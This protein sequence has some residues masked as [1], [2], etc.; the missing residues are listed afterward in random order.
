MSE[1]QKRVSPVAV[2]FELNIVQLLNLLTCICYAS[3]KKYRL[4]QHLLFASVSM[5]K[6]KAVPDDMVT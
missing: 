3:C 2:L 4:T 5:A 6:N 1:K